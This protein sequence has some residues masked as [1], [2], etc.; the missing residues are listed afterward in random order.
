MI[1]LA[2]LAFALQ[3]IPGQGRTIDWA[4]LAPLPFRT[5]PQITPAMRDFVAG[6][7]ALRKCPVPAGPGQ[8][9]TVDVAVLVAADDGI[10]TVIPRAIRCPTVE[11][12]TAA[13]VAGAA[14]DNLL[15]RTAAN[16]QWYRAT[17][18]FDWSR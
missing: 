12:Y 6:E 11:Q 8:T 3:A 1:A 16:E 2:A 5:L 9:L 13:L 17:I 18:T 14:R 4:A 15:P 7:I 10:R